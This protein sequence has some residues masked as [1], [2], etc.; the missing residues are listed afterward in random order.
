MADPFRFNELIDGMIWHESRNDPSAKSDIG[1]RGLMQIRPEDAHD[2]WGHGAPS[3]FDLGREMGFD[4]PRENTATA[5]RLLHDPVLNR[6][7]G[8]AYFRDIL[9]AFGGNIDNALTAYNA[10]PDAMQKMLARGKGIE[11]F[12]SEQA[13]NYARKVR[14]EYLDRAGIAFPE[15]IDTLQLTRPQ[16]RPVGLLSM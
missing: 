1:A 9:R 11:D 12:A 5:D 7:L 6:T 14:Q 10:G 4:V 16:A 13:R 2:L 3:V 8:T 15:T